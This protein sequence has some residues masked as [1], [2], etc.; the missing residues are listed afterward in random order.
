MTDQARS[1]ECW[2]KFFSC[3]TGLGSGEFGEVLIPFLQSINFIDITV[4]QITFDCI[5]ET[6]IG[7]I[8]SLAGF[9]MD[10]FKSNGARSSSI[11]SEFVFT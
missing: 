3:R 9:L 7:D 1:R 5:I 2:L 4:D 10:S 6:R 11:I 8:K